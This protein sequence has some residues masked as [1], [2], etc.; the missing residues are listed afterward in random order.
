MQKM[1]GGWEVNRSADFEAVI[2]G[3][4]VSGPG[5]IKSV[6]TNRLIENCGN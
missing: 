2:E 1:T 3:M 4:Y 6:V 5:Y